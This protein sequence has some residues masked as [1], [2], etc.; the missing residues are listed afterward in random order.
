M[1]SLTPSPTCGLN[2][3]LGSR[4][5]PLDLGRVKLVGHVDDVTVDDQLSILYS[6]GSRV[7]AMD[8]VVLKASIIH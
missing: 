3:V 2:D 8:S 4:L 6:Y 7:L 5:A 1:Q